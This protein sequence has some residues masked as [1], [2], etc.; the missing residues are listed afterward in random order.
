MFG[1]IHL[2]DV[3]NHVDYGHEGIDGDW[4]GSANMGHSLPNMQF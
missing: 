1:K 3:N 2:T 4:H